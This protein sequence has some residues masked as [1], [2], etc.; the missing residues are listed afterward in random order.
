MSAALFG[1][2]W[3]VAILL[4]AGANV[5]AIDGDGATA[6]HLAVRHDAGPEIVGALVSAGANPNVRDN[7]DR[8]PLGDA[9]VSG[10]ADAVRA[11]T[12]GR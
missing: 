5:N 10:K 12:A 4:A 9:R 7:A 8:S 3:A 1:H 11:M 2:E 6:L